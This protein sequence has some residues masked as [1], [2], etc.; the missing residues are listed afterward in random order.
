MVLTMKQYTANLKNGSTLTVKATNPDFA[1][2]AA[3]EAARKL[4]TSVRSVARIVPV[5]VR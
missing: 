2:E 5:P 1:L 3:E 4:G